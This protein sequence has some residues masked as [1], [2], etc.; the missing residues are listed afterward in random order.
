V[1]LSEAYP[2]KDRALILDLDETL[3]HSC[4]QRENP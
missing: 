4:T 3:I 2:K 1:Q